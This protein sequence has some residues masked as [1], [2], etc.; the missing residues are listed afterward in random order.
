MR[1]CILLLSLSDLQVQKKYE[2]RMYSVLRRYFLFV[3][4]FTN[5]A[6]YRDSKEYDGNVLPLRILKYKYRI[7]AINNLH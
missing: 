2:T 4:W 7:S 5:T 3:I 6:W 1:K